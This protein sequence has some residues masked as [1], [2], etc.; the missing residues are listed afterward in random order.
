MYGGMD[1]SLAEMMDAENQRGSILGYVNNIK[2][3]VMILADSYYAPALELR[4]IQIG[5]KYDDMNV[6]FLVRPIQNV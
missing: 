2:P 3:K 5:Q 4:D 6:T 1:G